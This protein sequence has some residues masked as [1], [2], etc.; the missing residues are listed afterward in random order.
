MNLYVSNLG[1]QVTDESLRAIFATHGA[2]SSS[3]ITRDRL[4]RSF[5]FVKMNN[6]A[7]AQKAI[8]Q[9]HGF[10]VNGL[11]VS[12]QEAPPGMELKASSGKG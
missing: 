12:V 4:S 8:S 5:A 1:D 10:V 9:I 6:E 2:V 11:A 3:K 7:E